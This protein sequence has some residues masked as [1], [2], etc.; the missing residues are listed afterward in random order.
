MWVWVPL[1]IVFW[2]LFAWTL[3]R[4]VRP[5]PQ[6]PLCFSRRGHKRACPTRPPPNP[7]QTWAGRGLHLLITG[8]M[9]FFV[10][11]D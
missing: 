5:G 8:V 2:V 1:F 4:V 9:N 3:W 10:R 6:C 11:D 7:E